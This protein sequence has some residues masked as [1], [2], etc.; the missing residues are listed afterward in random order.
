MFGK[1]V[2]P[3]TNIDGWLFVACLAVV[4]TIALA[5]VHMS[6]KAGN[7]TRGIANDNIRRWTLGSSL[8]SCGRV[9]TSEPMAAT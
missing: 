6:Q 3:T 7:R 4:A 1:L 2:T 5:V 9:N 8:R